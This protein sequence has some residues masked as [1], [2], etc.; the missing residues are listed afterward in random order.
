MASDTPFRDQ[1]SGNPFFA[2]LRPE[3][4]DVLAANAIHRRLEQDNVLFHYGEKA[5]HFYVILAGKVFV[6]VAAL[7]GPPL[8]LQSLESGAVLGWSWLIPPYLWTFQ[9]RADEDSE[10]LDFD[11]EALRAR[12]DANPEFGYELLKRFSGLMSERLNF[13]RRKMMEEWRP[14]GF[15]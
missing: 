4:I 2:G 15:A 6:E 10:V 3:F 7:E 9:A 8:P 11:G 5:D 14:S 12:C 13:A 1:I